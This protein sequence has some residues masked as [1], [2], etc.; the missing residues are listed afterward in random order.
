MSYRQTQTNI[1]ASSHKVV[2]AANKDR[3]RPPGPLRTV[4]EIARSLAVP[5][6]TLVGAISAACQHATMEKP[7]LPW[8]RY[9]GKTYYVERDLIDWYRR[10]HL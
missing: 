10:T 1:D 8:S 4:E 2:F 3:A 6:R 7:P 5:R 9:T